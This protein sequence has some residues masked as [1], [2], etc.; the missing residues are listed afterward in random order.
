MN[1]CVVMVCGI[2]IVEPEKERKIQTRDEMNSN[3]TLQCVSTTSVK[4]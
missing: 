3:L 4:P 1:T 2:I